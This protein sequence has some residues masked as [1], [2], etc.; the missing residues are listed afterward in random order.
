VRPVVRPHVRHPQRVCQRGRGSTI[1]RQ[2]RRERGTNVKQ[3]ARSRGILPRPA[4]RRSMW[5]D[6]PRK[7]APHLPTRGRR[8][9]LAG[10]G[11][12]GGG[13]GGGGRGG[14]G[15][16][17]GARPSPPRGGGRAPPPP[18]PPPP[19]THRSAP[20]APRNQR[21]RVCNM[22]EQ[23]WGLNASSARSYRSRGRRRT[24]A[25]AGYAAPQTRRRRY[26]RWKRQS[27]Q[28][29]RGCGRKR[30]SVALA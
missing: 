28:W 19:P 26:L 12:G 4:P 6:W 7:A 23:A 9:A 13:R 21:S 10:G 22:C 16:G 18:P 5:G 8:A 24:R 2:G 30:R 1:T 11:G 14:G 20:Y 27:E 25:V 29:R 17:G 3:R 15:G